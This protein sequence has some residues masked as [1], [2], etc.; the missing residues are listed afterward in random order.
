MKLYY[1][2]I[3]LL[4]LNSCSKDDD[5]VV[6]STRITFISDIGDIIYEN[7][8]IIKIGHQDLIY[9][10]DG[11]L[12]RIRYL[13]RDTIRF[14][15][16]NPMDSI[17]LDSLDFSV[18]TTYYSISI[19]HE[20]DKTLTILDTLSI[21]SS[22]LNSKSIYNSPLEIF[23]H[24]DNFQIDSIIQLNY[25]EEIQNLKFEKA[26]FTYDQRGNLIMNDTYCFLLRLAPLGNFDE[27]KFPCKVVYND[28]DSGINPMKLIGKNIYPFVPILTNQIYSENNPQMII[29]T[30]TQP[31]REIQLISDLT[32]IYNQR[33]YPTLISRLQR[34][35]DE[36]TQTI[37]YTD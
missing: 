9:S 31:D 26:I 16:I 30:V 36:R 27:E 19:E 37:E 6:D 24:S 14:G 15:F 4:V 29:V 18:K 33:N 32:Y 20:S 35:G 8:R 25:F 10:D 1:V 13:K 17:N 34:N 11:E 12:S 5:I 2:L 28:F 3:L 23:Y 7:D 22:P 21:S